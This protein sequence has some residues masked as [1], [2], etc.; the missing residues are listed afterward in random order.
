MAEFA[1]RLGAT[2]VAEGIETEA[3]LAAV[4]DLRM[5]AGQGYLLGR[6][7]V[8]EHDWEDWRSQTQTKAGRY[9]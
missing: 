2:I 6:P 1:R 3:E 9:R 8:H 5:A 7:T 4:T